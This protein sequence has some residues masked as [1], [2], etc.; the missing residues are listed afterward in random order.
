MEKLAK[1]RKPRTRQND[2]SPVAA[3]STAAQPEENL[4]G[5]KRKSR[6]PYTLESVMQS[7]A[8][9]FYPEQITG[10][11]AE[12]AE[13]PGYSEKLV[14]DLKTR[15]QELDATEMQVLMIVHNAD[16]DHDDY[17][18]PAAEKP[19]IH[20]IMRFID[21]M[22]NGNIR[23]ERIGTILEKLGVTY[24]P[25]VDKTLWEQHGVEAIGDFVEYSNYLLHWTEKAKKAGKHCYE[26]NELISNLPMD[27]VR[28]ILNGHR[29]ISEAAP[30]ENTKTQIETLIGLD[31]DAYQLGYQ[32]QD[33][34]D[35]YGSLPFV[36]RSHQSMKTIRESYFRGV[37]ARADD[38]AKNGVLRLCIFIEGEPDCGKTYAAIHALDKMGIS[39]LQIGGGGTGK[40]DKLKPSHGA[41]VIDDDLCPNLL[42]MSD[43][44]VCQA[45]RR[46]RN[47]PY[48]CGQYLVVTSNLTFPDW[49]IACGFHKCIAQRWNPETQKMDDIFE[50]HDALESRFYICRMDDRELKLVSP[51]KRGTYEEQT[52]RLDMFACFRDRFEE[53]AVRYTKDER[54]VDYEWALLHELPFC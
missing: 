43:N 28:K 52:K 25:D 33:F 13:E 27:E 34:D 6:S 29:Q 16:F 5:K 2:T 3:E 35:W 9:K 36:V 15:I 11:D 14:L 10:Y 31:R 49:L 18:D 32:L 40:L 26:L 22:P 19:H 45:Y 21:K 42:N 44:Y 38:P 7:I 54:S 39:T 23:R 47:N 53:I 17:W 20:I 24:R 30:D 46:N 50:H 37:T 12:H 48:W 41:I 4:I 8:L 1:K 51:S